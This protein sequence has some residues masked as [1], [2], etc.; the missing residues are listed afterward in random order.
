MSNGDQPGPGEGSTSAETMFTAFSRL[1]AVAERDEEVRAALEMLGHALLALTVPLE[2]EAADVEAAIPATAASVPEARPTVLDLFRSALRGREVESTT[3]EPVAVQAAPPA[4]I[5]R[6]RPVLPPPV[7]PSIPA[8]VFDIE[9]LAAAFRAK[10]GAAVWCAQTRAGGTSITSELPPHLAGD[11]SS[12]QTWFADRLTLH[13]RPERAYRQLAGLFAALEQA[14]DFAAA[15]RQA[16]DPLFQPLQLLAEAQSM[17]RVAAREIGEA[18]D[19][20]QERVYRFLRTVT[21]EFSVYLPRFM[22]LDDPGDPAAWED[23]QRRIDAASQP[24]RDRVRRE[25]DQRQA[26]SRLDFHLDALSAPEPNDVEH[27]WAETFAAIDTLI[28]AGML[29]PS[30]RELRERLLPLLDSRPPGIAIGEGV[31]LVLREI[32]RYLARLEAEESRTGEPAAVSV[33]VARV[34]EVLDGRSIVFIG[35]EPRVEHKDRIERVFHLREM[36]WLEGYGRSY[37]SYEPAIARDDVAIVVLALRWASHESMNVQ[38]YCEQYGKP[39]ITLK[40]GYN[41]NQLA[42]QV[43]AQAGQRLGIAPI[44]ER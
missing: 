40:S 43:I 2:P 22:K 20:D 16:G 42:S 8:P 15:S 4:P 28:D 9:E 27:H 3:P 39:L 29:Q 33:D 41:A 44:P 19:P 26:Q 37:R 13:L 24:L 11:L 17:L 38:V 31:A 34:A 25:R 14:L 36:V 10:S 1:A 18:I 21:S 12:R 5:V 6:P 23:I 30:N 7:I 32:D 35:G